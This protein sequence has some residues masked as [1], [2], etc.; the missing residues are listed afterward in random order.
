MT[1]MGFSPGEFKTEHVWAY[2]VHDRDYETNTVHW[3]AGDNNI[4]LWYPNEEAKILSL[5]YEEARRCRDQLNA[6]L[7][8]IGQE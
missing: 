5:S 6:A 2:S 4:T 3:E 7:A 8:A 1:E